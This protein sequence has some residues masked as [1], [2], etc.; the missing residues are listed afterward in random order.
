MKTSKILFGLFFLVAIVACSGRSS[1]SEPIA[2]HVTGSI[3]GLTRATTLTLGG[4]TL[5]MQSDGQFSFTTNF[6]DGASFSVTSSYNPHQVC[7]S[8]NGTVTG[9]DAT[10]AIQCRGVAYFNGN[11]TTDGIDL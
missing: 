11:D 4:E 7:D 1:E 5:Q 8:V 3:T 10:I 9:S 2:Y 6:A